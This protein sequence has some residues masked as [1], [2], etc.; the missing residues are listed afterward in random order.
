MGGDSSS[1]PLHRLTAG[2]LGDDRGRMAGPKSGNVGGYAR[3]V[4]EHRWGDAVGFGEWFTGCLGKC[5]RM[6]VGWTVR[7]VYL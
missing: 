4:R 2:L 1:A 7:I 6:H 5:F 3:N